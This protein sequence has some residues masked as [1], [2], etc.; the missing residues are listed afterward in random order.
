MSQHKTDRAV[1]FELTEPTGEAVAAWIDSRHLARGS[2]LFPDRQ[3]QQR[4]LS[5]RQY[6]RFIQQ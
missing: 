2:F 6:A 3:R 5:T 4:H 1:R